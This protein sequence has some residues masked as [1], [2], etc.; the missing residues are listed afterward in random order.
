MNYKIE[1]VA[2]PTE[3]DL[4]TLSDGLDR[5]TESHIGV[6]EKKQLTFFIRDNNN[7]VIG[8]IAGSYGSYGWLW[9]DTLWLSEQVRGQGLGAKLLRSIE[10]EALN[11]GC[12]NAYLNSFSFSAVEFYKKC[13]YVVYGELEDFPVGHSVCSLRKKLVLE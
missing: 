5:F 7:E 9:I 12:D 2:S 13:G 3:K 10:Q 8:G 6:D 11:N 4:K 1:N